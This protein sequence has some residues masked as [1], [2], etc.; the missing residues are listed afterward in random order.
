MT[1]PIPY[2][3]KPIDRVI[4][5]N[6]LE[7]YQNYRKKHDDTDA[8]DGLAYDERTLHKR[9]DNQTDAESVELTEAESRLLY[10]VALSLGQ[11]RLD[12]KKPNSSNGISDEGLT[13]AE[14]FVV[15]VL[16]ESQGR[17]TSTL[18]L[19]KRDVEVLESV[20][21]DP[22]ELEDYLAGVKMR[23][24]VQY[25]PQVT[26]EYERFKSLFTKKRR[27]PV[28][29]LVDTELVNY[30]VAVTEAALKQVRAG[31]PDEDQEN[32]LEKTLQVLRKA[33]G[34]SMVF[35]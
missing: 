30:G 12:A 34:T 17:P 4:A 20:L 27:H 31:A 2:E 25:G 13:D 32:G 18:T 14:M 15:T 8:I 16:R 22:A 9:L 7:V 21:Y 24:L 28:T 35:K 3:A 23:R 26:A 6:I 33:G 10:D 1:T 29:L 5:K 19:D 11:Y